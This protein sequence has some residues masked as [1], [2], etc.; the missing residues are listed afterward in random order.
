MEKPEYH[1]SASASSDFETGSDEQQPSVPPV[2]LERVVSV[3]NDPRTTNIVLPRGAGGFPV[4]PDPQ[5]F[6]VKLEPTD[7]KLSV[8]WPPMKKYKTAGYALMC[9]LTASWGSSIFSSATLQFMKYFKIHMEVALLGMS[10]YVC[11][12]ASGPVIFAPLSELLGRKLPLWLGMFAFSCFS[13]G[14]ATAADVHTV[15]ICRFFGGFF[16]SAPMTIVGALFSD[17]FDNKSRGKAVCV[18][19]ALTFAGPLL[20]PIVGGFI[21]KS[22]LG[23]RWTEYITSFMGFG[24]CLILPLMPETYARTITENEAKR[25]RAECNNPFIHAKSEEETMTLS[26]V[27]RNYFMIPLRLLFTEPIVLLLTLYMSFVYGILYLLLEAYPII[28]SETHHFIQGVSSL[29][30]IGLVIGVFCGSFMTVQFEPWYFRQVIKAGGKPVPEARLPPMI[31]GSIL[32]PGGIFWLCWSGAYE[33]VHWIVPALSGILTGWG[34]LCIFMQSMN[35][36][37]DAYLFRAASVLA[38]NTI[39]RSFV[40]A[41][42]PLFAVQMFHN[43]GTGWAGT[44]IGL[45][46]VAMIPIPVLFYIYGAR[47]RKMSKMTVML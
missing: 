13:I 47:I 28:F 23:W 45:L 46:S 6:I 1:D 14:T 33:S 26:F 9:T 41:G 38:A 19:A 37:V 35:Y 2:A 30:Y 4:V 36:L 27:V 44:L 12:F 31:I 5:E 16:A 25:L 21:A 15:L 8:N 3:T 43:L 40:G 17:M 34:I 29:P 39:M 42:F 22:Y 20:A 32:F 11:G 18:F 7:P 24:I 10:L